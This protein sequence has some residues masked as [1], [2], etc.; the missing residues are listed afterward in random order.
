MTVKHGNWNLDVPTLS[1]G[2]P[3]TQTDLSI[4][5]LP[6]FLNASDRPNRKETCD[7]LWHLEECR[8]IPFHRCHSA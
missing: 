5:L 4:Q 2:T 8:K 6:M 7:F 1:I 3:R